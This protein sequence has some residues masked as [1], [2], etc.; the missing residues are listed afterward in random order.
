MRLAKIHSWLLLCCWASFGWASS[1]FSTEERAWLARHP[2]VRYAIDPH[3]W[4]IEY[5]EDGKHKGLTQEYLQR[6]ADISG[7]RFQLVPVQNRHQ[8]MGMLLSGKLDLVTATSPRLIP[9]LSTNR[10]CSAT[11]TFPAAPFWSLGRTSP[12]F[13]IR[14]GYPE[15]WSRWS[16]AIRTSI[17]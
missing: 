5:L 2:V 8:A 9:P 3:G 10:C 17:F 4:P 16:K 15:K 7:I 12:S 6:I 1:P 13:S 14:A 11:P